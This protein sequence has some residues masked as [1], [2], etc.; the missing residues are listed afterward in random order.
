MFSIS[1]DY[2]EPNV[3]ILFNNSIGEAFFMGCGEQ[4]GL[5]I[6]HSKIHD[7]AYCSKCNIYE[8]LEKIMIP[9]EYFDPVV[10]IDSCVSFVDNPLIKELNC[11]KESF[12]LFRRDFGFK[13]NRARGI[14][15]FHHAFSRDALCVCLKEFCKRLEK[16]AV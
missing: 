15:G 3:G 12:F 10:F 16:Y 9:P 13:H 4:G 2:G 5:F 1:E 8:F 11:G 6:Q 7:V 14:V